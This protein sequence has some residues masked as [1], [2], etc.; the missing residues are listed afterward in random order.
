MSSTEEMARCIREWAEDEMQFVSQG[1]LSSAT[2]PPTA[3][4]QQMCSGWRMLELWNFVTKFVKSAETVKKV[5]GNL[6]LD[7]KM[8]SRGGSYKV[9][10]KGKEKYS[11]E[12]ASL[13]DHYEEL[14][15]QIAQA[16]RDAGTLQTEINR[17]EKEMSEAERIQTQTCTQTNE[18]R[19]GKALLHAY[20]KQCE[21]QDAQY[22]EY[23]TRVQQLIE[24]FQ[25]VSSRP[26]NDKPAYSRETGAGDGAVESACTHDVRQCTKE[27][28]GFLSGILQGQFG[29]DKAQLSRRKEQLWTV[30]ENVTHEHPVNHVLHSLGIIAEDATFHLRDVTARVDVKNEVER[31]SFDHVGPGQFR[32]VSSGTST[33]KGVQQLLQ[34]AQVSHFHQ[35]IRTEQSLNA[36]WKERQ[37]LDEAKARL[38]KILAGKMLQA[39]VIEL[40]KSLLGVELELAGAQA[41]LQCLQESAG[42]LE[43]SARRRSTERKAL[44]EKHSQIQ[45]FQITVERKQDLIRVLTKQNSDSKPRLVTLQREWQQF[46]Q[47]QLCIHESQVQVNTLQLKGAVKQEVESLL[48]LKL[49]ALKPAL[50]DQPGLM[51]VRDLSLYAVDQ[52]TGAAEGDSLRK[53]AED[54]HCKPFKAAECLLPQ[55]IQMKVDIAAMATLLKSHDQLMEELQGV[56]QAGG[57]QRAAALCGEVAKADR[58]ML[59]RLLPQLEARMDKTQQ[60]MGRALRVRDFKDAWWDQPAQHLAPWLEQGGQTYRQ[61]CTAWTVGVA[62]LHQARQQFQ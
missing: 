42:E 29:A 41:A 23:T 20:S 10:Y 24:Q 57:L 19:H 56:R 34:E 26:V 48:P 39:G 49:S 36:V 46:M 62:H 6:F 50:L 28:Q 7:A 60:V 30:V 33:V 13:Q 40:T 2:L 32:D 51:Q 9:R 54:V 43:T 18:L 31:L 16:R 1:Y 47:R 53:V 52:E 55:V 38:E 21:A 25:K 58:S 11:D 35:F 27:L 5:R 15:S 22:K 59:E 37:A 17:M 4:L 61:W 8:E 12:D 14:Q 44:E 3:E 45:D